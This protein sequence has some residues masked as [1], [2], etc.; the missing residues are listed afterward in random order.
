MPR[1]LV[2][3]RLSTFPL[4]DRILGGTLRTELEKRRAEGDS[5]D[6]IARWLATEHDIQ[7]TDETVR[8]WCVRFP[9]EAGQAS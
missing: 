4:V 5:Y 6:A 9:D 1:M 3:A 8:G 2:V 7:V